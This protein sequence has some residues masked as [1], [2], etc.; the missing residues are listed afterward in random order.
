MILK[1]EAINLFFFFFKKMIEKK[2]CDGAK[3][4]QV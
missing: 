3:N 1:V 2:I 4:R